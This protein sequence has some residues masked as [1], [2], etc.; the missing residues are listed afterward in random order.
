M[1]YLL[2][3]HA[4]F[5]LV[6]GSNKLGKSA[7]LSLAK[8]RDGQIAISD[9]TLFELAQLEARGTI[10]LEPSA[11]SFLLDL[12]QRVIV[13]PVDGEIAADAAH[14]ALPHGDPFDRLIVATAR[15]HRLTLVTRDGNIS[16]SELVK[17]LW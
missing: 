8:A 9:T 3:T 12:A 6:T 16:D 17:V 1:K 13:L 2:D 7:K 10:S 14:L 5:W 4:I 15:R 11:S